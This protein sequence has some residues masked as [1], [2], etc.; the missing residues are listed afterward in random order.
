ME[1]RCIIYLGL[2]ITF[3]KKGN[4]HG[5]MELYVGICRDNGLSF[6]LLTSVRYTSHLNRPSILPTFFPFVSSLTLFLSA[7]SG[8]ILVAHDAWPW[9]GIDQQLISANAS[10]TLSPVYHSLRFPPDSIV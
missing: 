6:I 1:G 5:C 4:R 10:P 7:T 2:A 8:G 3:W 9:I